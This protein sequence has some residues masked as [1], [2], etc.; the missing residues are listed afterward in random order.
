MVEYIDDG[1]VIDDMEW[2]GYHTMVSCT[3]K[4]DQTVKHVPCTRSCMQTSH[5]TLHVAIR[6][7]TEPKQSRALWAAR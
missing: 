1:Y 2:Y 4:S 7:G 3:D 6:N 5:V